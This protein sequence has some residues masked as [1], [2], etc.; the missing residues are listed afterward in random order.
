M[1]LAPFLALTLASATQSSPAPGG[2]RPLARPPSD[3]RLALLDAMGQESARSMERLR[4]TGYEA[5]Y[6]LSY[7]LKELWRH[8]VSGRYGA[9]FED[10]D[11]R[12]R[13]LL[14]DVR[15]GS[16]AFDSSG[17]LLAQLAHLWRFS[18]WMR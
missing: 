2:A 14:V 11:R 18:F 9:V 1:H 6:F 7:Q 15:V 13:K 10:E 3:A 17:P 5:P 16:Y 12:E 4:L 8:E